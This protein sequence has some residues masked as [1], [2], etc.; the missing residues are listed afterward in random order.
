M[1]AVGV[2]EILPL[3]SA[4]YQICSIV[5]LWAF[6][7]H[8]II[9][10]IYPLL[11]ESPFIFHSFVSSVSLRTLLF[12]SNHLFKIFCESI[13]FSPSISFIS[14][15]YFLFLKI[16]FIPLNDFFAGNVFSSFL[17]SALWPLTLLAY[18]WCL[19]FWSQ[20][21]LCLDVLWF[22]WS[23]T[24]TCTVVT[25]T[26]LYFKCHCYHV[27]I[28]IIKCHVS[29]AFLHA[30]NIII[31]VIWA[32]LFFNL[33]CHA[34]FLGFT[35]RSNGISVRYLFICFA[36][37]LYINKGLLYI[38]NSSITSVSTCL[39]ECPLLRA[40]VHVLFTLQGQHTVPSSACCC[41]DADALLPPPSSFLSNECSPRLHR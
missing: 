36:L 5:C 17:I 15:F 1:V 30:K 24:F 22:S 32:W 8:V 20:D 26:V 13:I 6:V 25:T 19:F 40:L 3:P 4:F 2:N 28:I 23:V 18:Q 38:F 31:N 12:S 34:T 16:F 35:V 11:L 37:S 41:T 10:H 14:Y 33:A 39:L 7:L 29:S 21:V 9:H 27:K